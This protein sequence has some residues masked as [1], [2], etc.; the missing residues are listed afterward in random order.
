MLRLT[1]DTNCVIHG[2]QAQPYGPQI[3][4]LVDLA[5]SGRVVLSTTEAFAVDQ[6][7]AP[8]D[9]H[10]RN[11]E[12]LSERT[13]I[14]RVPGPCRVGYSKRGGPDVAVGD[15]HA[16]VNAALTEILLAARYQTGNLKEDDEAL[17]ARW[18][19]KVTDVQHLTAH[20]MARHDAFVTSDQDDM[21]DKREAIRQRT[22][23]VVVDPAEA[24]AMAR[25][26]GG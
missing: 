19:Q 8:A 5:Q 2:A 13:V 20:L 15:D 17:M 22:G 7:T 4:E 3:D 9:K 11:L 6:E 1:L 14:A 18:R 26:Q 23:I 12:W 10:R 25:D 21:L 16:A 24:L